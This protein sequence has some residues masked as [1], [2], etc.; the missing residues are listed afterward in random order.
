MPSTLLDHGVKLTENVQTHVLP[1]W[2]IRKIEIQGKSG[3]VTLSGQ[4]V[5]D[6]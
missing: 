6:Y 1:C 3:S 2:P 4:G 5:G